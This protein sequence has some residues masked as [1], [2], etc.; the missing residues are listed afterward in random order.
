MKKVISIDFDGTICRYQKYGNGLILES[1]MPGA[2]EAIT[3]LKKEGFKIIVHTVRLNPSFGGDLRWKEW[4]IRHWMNKYG[5][6][7]DGN[8]IS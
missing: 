6:P 8:T 4:V 5:I 7:F 2:K 1:P 3:K